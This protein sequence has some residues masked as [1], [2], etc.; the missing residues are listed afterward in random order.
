MDILITKQIT[1]DFEAE[2]VKVTDGDTIT[3]RV[4]WRDFDF[5][6]R[7]ARINAPEMNEEGG[8]ESKQWLEEKILGRTI[9]V[10]IKRENRVGK[11]GRLLGEA[12]HEAVL[13]AG[14]GAIHLP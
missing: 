1:E 12:I 7:M 13:A 11:F 2:V 5:K 10:Q 14:K 3:L 8:E 9:D 4:P 6:L